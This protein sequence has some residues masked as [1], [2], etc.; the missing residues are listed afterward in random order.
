MIDVR[1]TKQ[2]HIYRGGIKTKLAVKPIGILSH[3][4][5]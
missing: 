2:Q 3:T 1:M 4:L 5:K